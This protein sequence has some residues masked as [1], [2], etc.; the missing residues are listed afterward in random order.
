V[1]LHP[2]SLILNKR[3][4][5]CEYHLQHRYLHPPMV[6]ESSMDSSLRESKKRDEQ[7]L[8]H[9]DDKGDNVAPEL[10]IVGVTHPGT[11]LGACH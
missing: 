1:V 2:K 11:G 9:L 8:H 4:T 10:R 6:Q 7:Y 5:P 3:R